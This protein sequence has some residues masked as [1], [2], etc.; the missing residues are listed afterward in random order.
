LEIQMTGKKRMNVADYLRGARL[1][2]PKT[3]S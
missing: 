1:H 2:S 3:I